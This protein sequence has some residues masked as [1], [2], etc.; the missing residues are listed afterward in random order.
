MALLKSRPSRL[1]ACVDSNVYIS[2]IAFG[3][4]PLKVVERAMN[5]EFLLVTGANILKEVRRNLLGKL[6]LEQRRVDS[7]LSD[8]SAVSSVF[9]PSGT[10]SAT[11]NEGDNLVLEVAM[12]G[13]ADVLVTGD[14][15]HLL[16]LGTFQ[17]IVIESPSVFLL[18]LDSIE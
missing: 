7:F 4:K 10:V 15:K 5:R 13:G 17:G 3:G 8:I 18:R 1:S 2:A 14:K 16:P 11:D 9:V 12:M 6:S